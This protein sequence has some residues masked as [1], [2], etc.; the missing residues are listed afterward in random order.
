MKILQV[1]HQFPPHSYTGTEVYAYNLSRALQRAG[2][3]V[4]V[5]YRVDDPMMQEYKITKKDDEG[6]E[7]FIINNTF[8][9]YTGFQDTYCNKVISEKFSCILDELQPDVVHVQH[10]MYLSSD[11]V[12]K[13]KE[14]GI[15]IV[16]TLNDYW[17]LCPQGQLLR[18]NRDLCNSQRSADCVACVSYQLSIIMHIFRL[19]YFFKKYVS[20]AVINFL[21]KI[22]FRLY[23]FVNRKKLSALIEQRQDYLREV[24]DAAD[25]LIAPSCFLRDQFV[26]KGV[27]ENK[28]VSCGYGFDLQPMGKR[29]ERPDARLRF[30]FIGNLLPAKGVH[31]LIDAFNSIDPLRAQLK[32]Y[33]RFSSYKSV[34]ENYEEKIM[35]M[36][37]GSHI[38][39]EGGFDH[40][41]IIKILSG[42]DLLVVPSIWRENAPLVIQEAFWARIPVL[43]SNVGGIPEF[44]IDGVN[45]VLFKPGNV[46]DLRRKINKIIEDPCLIETLKKNIIPPKSMGQHVQEM[47][48]LYQELLLT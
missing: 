31:V 29:P 3:D 36:M 39:L 11:I 33:G 47:L 37:R 48:K 10:L 24:L 44:V 7:V 4:A 35:N 25:L 14:R 38:Q 12:T 28:I 2:H 13:V 32:I 19:Y 21:K 22:Y 42:L 27:A 17:T 20:S 26:A 5:F 9:A 46:Q 45:G 30:G 40:T 23:L 6:I 43:A 8:R 1:V 41:D 34:T 16:L 15:P 18:N